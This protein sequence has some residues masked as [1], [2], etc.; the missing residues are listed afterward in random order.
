MAKRSLLSEHP[1]CVCVCVYIYIYIYIY[2]YHLSSSCYHTTRLRK[3]DV[4]SCF[5]NVHEDYHYPIS[6]IFLYC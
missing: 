2:V 5:R 3:S 4:G 6:G 1:S